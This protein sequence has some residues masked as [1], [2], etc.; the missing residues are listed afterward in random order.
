MFM[1]K[2]ASMWYYNQL[3]DYNMKMLL[4]MYY[5]PYMVLGKS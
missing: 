3:F 4:L 2:E 1:P 5:L